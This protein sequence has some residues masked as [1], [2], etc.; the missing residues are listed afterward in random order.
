MTQKRKRA[1]GAGR[2][3]GFSRKT[4]KLTMRI[5]PA[6]RILLEEA[7]KKNKRSLSHEAEYHLSVSLGKDRSRRRGSHIQALGEMIELLAQLIEKKTD[8]H[9]NKDV[10]TGEALR[11]GIE[12][13][14][15]HFAPRGTPVTPINLEKEAAKIAK[16]CGVVWEA[17]RSP[18]GLGET[19]AGQVMA[20]IEISNFRV[21]LEEI[22]RV[23]ADLRKNIPGISFPKEEWYLHK[24]MFGDLKPGGKHPREK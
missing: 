21:D 8:K 10:F 17:Y 11:R 24:Q 16:M 4:A 1:P 13:L 9:W 20:W 18:V 22:G 7:A 15:S 14:V 23:N 2:K 12:V 19:E 6:T 3:P 5:E